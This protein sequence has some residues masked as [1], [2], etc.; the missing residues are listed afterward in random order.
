MRATSKLLHESFPPSWKGLSYPHRS[1]SIRSWCT[2]TCHIP[3]LV[4]VIHVLYRH[5]HNLDVLLPKYSILII[6]SNWLE[7][8]LWCIASYP[9]L[10]HSRPKRVH[11]GLWKDYNPVVLRNWFRF[12][13]SCGTDVHYLLFLN[14]LLHPTTIYVLSSPTVYDSNLPLRL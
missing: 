9:S 11:S 14:K 2:R 7:H 13:R 3:I 8:H 5:I 6:P 1:I 4:V 10:G 12:Q